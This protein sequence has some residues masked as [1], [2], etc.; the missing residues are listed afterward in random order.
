MLALEQERASR[1]D[2]GYYNDTVLQ[3]CGKSGRAR[4]GTCSCSAATPRPQLAEL[5]TNTGCND[6]AL[7]V[8]QNFL[9]PVS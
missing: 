4:A 8:P 9:H 1:V 6:V 7:S 5:I 3:D 2:R